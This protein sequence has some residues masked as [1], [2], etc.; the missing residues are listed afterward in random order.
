MPLIA[1]ESYKPR[2]DLSD[3]TTKKYVKMHPKKNIF[4]SFWCKSDFASLLFL[5]KPK[6]ILVLPIENFLANGPFNLQP[7]F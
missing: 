3:A 5:Q 7:L 6:K 4:H 1:N 2:L